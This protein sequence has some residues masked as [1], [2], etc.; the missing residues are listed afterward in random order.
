VRIF[1][2]G[3]TGFIGAAFIKLALSRGHEIA[4]L[5]RREPEGGLRGGRTN[6]TAL[7]GSL[8]DPPWEEIAAFQP[9]ACLHAAWIATPG[10]YLHSP[11]NADYATWTTS[12]GRRLREIGLAFFVGLGT[13]IEYE[14]SPGR[15]HLREDDTPLV[16]TTPYAKAKDAARAALTEV[17][18]GSETTFAWGR[19]FY[20]YG[21]GEHPA[22]L[23]SSLIRQLR[24]GGTARLQRP[25]NT[26]DYIFIDDVAAA[27]LAM[28]EQKVEGPVNVGT[29]DGV[30]VAELAQTIRNVLLEH[31]EA[32]GKIEEA[33][34]APA[35]Y[36]VADATLLRSVGWSPQV[37]LRAGIEAMLR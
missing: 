34:N 11:L 15:N 35:D 12:L 19:I 14:I 13:C 4:A 27:L 25:G 24:A 36:I 5:L 22:R 2:T 3:A 10:V 9:D 17:F 31:G 20:P 32:V 21:P 1:V 18:A 16:P 33:Q 26:N 37:S 6:V 29:G 23:C 28:V 8:A 30:T 7:I